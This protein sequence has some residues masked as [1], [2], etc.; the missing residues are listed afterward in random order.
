MVTL[1]EELAVA[2]AGRDGTG[3]APTVPSR[4]AA[5]AVA[6]GGS[7]SAMAAGMAGAPARERRLKIGEGGVV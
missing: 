6:W 5:V 4:R 1:S 7:W 2:G 3:T